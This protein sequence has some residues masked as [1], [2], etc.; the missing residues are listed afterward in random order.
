MTSDKLLKILLVEDSVTDARLLREH[1]LLSGVGDI[2]INNV[3]SLQQAIDF[4]KSNQVDATL[5]DLTLPDSSG[6]ETISRFRTAR[7]DMPIV[8]LTGIDDEKTGPTA[9]LSSAPSVTPLNANVWMMSF[10]KPT[11]S[12]NCASGKGR[13][14]FLK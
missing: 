5:L 10:A 1:I 14:N 3:M 4:L 12:W 6:L 2:Y 8:V 7:P 13:Q 9:C 11:T